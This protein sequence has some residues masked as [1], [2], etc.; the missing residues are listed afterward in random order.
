MLCLKQKHLYGYIVLNVALLI[1]KFHH[2]TVV[3]KVLLTYST[4]CLCHLLGIGH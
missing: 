2:H 1:R 3:I 4:Y